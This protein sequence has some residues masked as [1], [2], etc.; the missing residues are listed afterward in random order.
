MINLVELRLYI[1]VEII[2]WVYVTQAVCSLQRKYF[3]F[4]KRKGA[5]SISNIK[6]PISK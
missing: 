1:V 6:I 5:K 3:H 2:K 4:H